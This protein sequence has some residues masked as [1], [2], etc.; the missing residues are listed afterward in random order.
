MDRV[1]DHLIAP[2]QLFVRELDSRK[3]GSRLKSMGAVCCSS[4]GEIFQNANL[5]SLYR[6]NLAIQVEVSLGP[7]PKAFELW[8]SKSHNRAIHSVAK[9]GERIE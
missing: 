7:N 9:V 6:H 2:S 1:L 8:V 5:L 4:F 3:D